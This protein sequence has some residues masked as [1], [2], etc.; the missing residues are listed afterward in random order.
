MSGSLRNFA[1]LRLRPLQ[2]DILRLHW[3]KEGK[4]IQTYETPGPD[5]KILPGNEAFV[6]FIV[7]KDAQSKWDEKTDCGS[8]SRRRTLTST[9]TPRRNSNARPSN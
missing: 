7:Q 6:T 1:I 4:T 5:D 2:G 9:K 8:R 3:I